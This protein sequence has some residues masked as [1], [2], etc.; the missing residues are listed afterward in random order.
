MKT[1]IVLCMSVGVCALA[2]AEPYTYAWWADGFHGRNADGRRLLNVETSQYGAVL[3]VNGP[4]LLRLGKIEHPVPYAQAA[5]MNDEALVSL[6]PSGLRLSIRMGERVYNCVAAAMN[7]KDEAAY[8]VRLIEGGRWLHRYDIAGLDFRDDA[9]NALAVN[10]RLQIVAWPDRLTLA[11]L[12]EPD[13]ALTGAQAR[14]AIDTPTGEGWSEVVLG[15]EAAAACVGWPGAGSPKQQPRIVV[16]DP[17]DGGKELPVRYDAALDAQIVSI[18]AR[19]WD[20]SAELDRLDRFDVELR[21]H[22]R[23]TFAHVLFAM[24]GPLQGVTGLSPM[25]RDVAGNPLPVPVQISKNWHRHAERR[26]THEGAWL[27]AAACIDLAEDTNWS[28]QFNIAYARWGG[29]PAASHAQL[30]LVGWGV[31]Q[32]WDQ[33]AIGSFGE[34]ICYDPDVCLNRSMIDDVRPLM[35]TSMNN[36]QWSWTHNVGGG[37]FLVYV[38]DSGKRQ[39]LVG[40]KS[41]YLSQGPN[42][43]DVVYAGRSADGKFDARVEVMSPRCDDVNR[44]Y[45]RIRYDVREACAFSRLAFYQLGADN[46]NDHQFTRI[47]RGNADGLTEEWET[48]RGGKK[49]LRTAMPGEGRAPWVALLGGLRSKEAKQGAWADRA[50]VV[51]SWKARLGGKAC[52]SP[53][54]SIYGTENGIPS[55]NVELAPPVGLTQLEAGDFVEAEVE[56]LV[57]PQRVEDYYGPNAALRADLA[58]NGGTWRAAHRLARDND[59]QV[60]ATTGT[61]ESRIPVRVRADAEGLAEFALVG[62]TGYVPVSVSGVYR[63]SGCALTVDGTPLN[64]SVHGNDF[65]Q[66]TPAADGTVTWTFNVPV[67]AP[68]TRFR[69]AP[70]L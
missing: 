46:Y 29:V 32:R 19:Q 68:E 50:L 67:T 1:L 53:L 10:A 63:T 13:A 8:P 28:A 22:E 25:L 4:T 48:E 6:P 20:M 35:V 16:R 38:D 17:L 44:A 42:L 31:N 52:E 2:H 66:V 51:R 47:A 49:Y 65:W 12:V 3:D 70:V 23:A 27:R 57:L 11:L 5:K 40:M 33:A 43:T 45:H 60:T 21:T 37:D 39:P 30:C 58:A 34:S 56:L 61:V 69:F 9:G 36:G 14:I 26:L 59:L 41:A 64:Q 24:E 7:T 15:A 55:A 62:G 54:F 18:P